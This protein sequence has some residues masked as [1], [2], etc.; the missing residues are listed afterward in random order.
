[1]SESGTISC[2]EES[3]AR[4]DD[5]TPRTIGRYAVE[6]RVG[7]GGMG[8]VWAAHDPELNRRVAVKV[9]R[10]GT[11]SEAGRR[12]QIRL[13]REAQAMARLSHPNVVQVYDA[14]VDDDKVYVAME[15]VDGI[16][17]AQWLA[18]EGRSW[19]EAVQLFVDA[20]RGLAA[21]HEAGLVHRDFKPSNVLVGDD[22][23]VRVA[24]FGLAST[25]TGH[26]IDA[27][28]DHGATTVSTELTSRGSMIGTPRYMAPEQR[29]GHV[30]G[31][32]A[33]QFS[34]CVA[35][36][37]ALYDA[38]PYPSA[39][40][41]HRTLD[42]SDYRPPSNT[43]GVP[44][45][46]VEAVRRG[47]RID[48][49]AR[50]ESMNALLERIADAPHLLRR[51]LQR[52][53]FATVALGASAVGWSVAAAGPGCDASED[54]MGQVWDDARRDNLA[55]LLSDEGVP[56][57][58]AVDAYAQRWIDTGQQ[59]CEA[60]AD[61]LLSAPLMAA[62]ATCL[63]NRLHALD[64]Y[65][66]LVEAG[67]PG[68]RAKAAVA[69]N[70]LPSVGDCRDT[71][72]L[73]A[74]MTE[75]DPALAEQVEDLRR[76]TLLAT[77]SHHAGQVDA[78]LAEFAQVQREAA[79]SEHAPI[80]AEVGLAGGRLAMDRQDWAAAQP[81]LEDASSLGIASSRDHIAAE[82]EARLV[83][84]VAMQEGPEQ[85]LAH[86]R[87]ATALAQRVGDPPALRALIANNAGVGYG[88]L[89]DRL[90]A[91]TAFQRALDLSSGGARVD[92][93]DR[94]GYALN[95]ALLTEDPERRDA[96]FEQ[97]AHELEQAL[98]RNHYQWLDHMA[99]WAFHTEEPE[100]ALGRLE[101]L[102]P[103]LASRGRDDPMRAYRC[104]ARVAL[105][106]ELGGDT[107]GALDA[108]REAASALDE[109]VEP[110]LG[111]FRLMAQAYVAQFEDR[112]D[113]VVSLVDRASAVLEPAGA[114]PWVLAARAELEVLRA[115]AVGPSSVEALRAAISTLEAQREST[116]DQQPEL[117]RRRARAVLADFKRP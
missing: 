54:A 28:L 53:V 116:E 71:R 70:R 30:A 96:L 7:A 6:S 51:R 48:P 89:G 52:G 83:F 115:R 5:E 24:D 8:V 23:R 80:Q 38:R 11:G 13:V 42:E 27:A 16:T 17:A 43:L 20:G 21:A 61:G 88:I 79:E 81:Q 32:A 22:G 85:G 41:E 94:T 110:P 103:Q 12:G 35:L 86:E 78:A 63:D 111:A 95:V 102:C 15:F 106:Q 117:L 97:S 57:V 3:P 99:A 91:A 105:L 114:L 76:R 44:K 9:L 55:A 2:A 93:L 104:Y 82:A 84:V 31:P 45:V 69:A 67:E 1:M 100:Q 34:F 29:L 73:Q 92:P 74:G 75:G 56:V 77:V 64:R 19:R 62:S 37:E 60:H 14:G 113:D 108:A 4:A 36:H 90:G 98:G 10:P 40:R 66:T 50:F 68:V 107:A 26:A 46:V 59:S 72:M 101:P 112:P 18:D 47:L 33:D 109:V 65:L 49:E 39:T 58:R 87:V 25:A